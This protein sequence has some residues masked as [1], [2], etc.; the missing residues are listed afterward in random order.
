MVYPYNALLFSYEKNKVLIYATTRINNE[1]IMMSEK[2]WTESAIILY[3][4]IYIK[5]LE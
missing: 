1:K 2:N 4:S 3:D 5:C